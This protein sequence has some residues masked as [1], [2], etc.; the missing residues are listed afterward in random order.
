MATIVPAE[1]LALSKRL[2]YENLKLSF[3]CRS[4]Q[5]PILQGDLLRYEKVRFTVS[6]YFFIIGRSNWNILKGT[7]TKSWQLRSV[8]LY[9]NR[10]EF[11][12][13]NSKKGEVLLTDCEVKMLFRNQ[14]PCSCP[15]LSSMY[16]T[17]DQ[18]NT[19]DPNYLHPGYRYS[20]NF[21]IKLIWYRQTFIVAYFLKCRRWISCFLNSQSHWKCEHIGR[22]R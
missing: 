14:L 15:S 4:D 2:L 10:L 18:D 16:G 13:G 21:Q 11:Y 19:S 5:T 3:F 1:H 17:A 9:S 8:R 22:C 7:L 20:E 6:V 12:S